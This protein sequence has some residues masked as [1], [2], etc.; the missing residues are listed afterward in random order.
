MWLVQVTAQLV[1]QVIPSDF[2]SAAELLK[3][4]ANIKVCIPHQSS[5]ELILSFGCRQNMLPRLSVKLSGHV[6]EALIVA[7]LAF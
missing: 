6:I 5:L 7:E 4:L 3:G 1:D 2:I